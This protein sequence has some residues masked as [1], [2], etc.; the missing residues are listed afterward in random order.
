MQNT[1]CNSCAS[2]QT[3]GDCNAYSMAEPLSITRQTFGWGV[4]YARNNSK[5]HIMASFV[6]PSIIAKANGNM[7]WFPS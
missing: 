3:F 1:D 5:N 2:Q 7:L 6:S 4:T